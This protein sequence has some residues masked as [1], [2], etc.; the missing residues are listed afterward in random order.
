MKIDDRERQEKS[1]LEFMLRSPECRRI[2]YLISIQ[3]ARL[4]EP[5]TDG[6]E[7]RH[8]S[9]W[10]GRRNLGLEILALFETAQPATHPGGL[11]ILTLIQL[12]R[13]EA[14]KPSE[15]PNATRRHDRY[16]DLDS[17]DAGDG[18]GDDSDGNG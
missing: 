1:D 17:D 3:M 2:L 15:K 16:R 5:T 11:S 10:E 8:L 6:S 4:L 13:E 7:G 14:Q 9:Y 18:G 12:L